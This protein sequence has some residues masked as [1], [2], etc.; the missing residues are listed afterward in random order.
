[1]R[2]NKNLQDELIPEI[3]LVIYREGGRATKSKVEQKIFNRHK[4]I[5]DKPYFL[6]KVSHGVVRWKHFIAWS[7]ERGRQLYGYFK[8][9]EDSGRGIWEL[10]EKGKNFVEENLL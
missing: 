4:D 9:A 2:S 10:T 8:K 7:K 6:A 3:A 1:M 5:F